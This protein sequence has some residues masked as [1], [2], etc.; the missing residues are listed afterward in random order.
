MVKA[1]ALF[2]VRKVIPGRSGPIAHRFEWL[3]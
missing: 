2:L 1:M 3:P